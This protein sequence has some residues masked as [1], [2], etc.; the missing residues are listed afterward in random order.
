MSKLEE[1]SALLDGDLPEDRAAQLRQA[2]HDD[3]AIAAAWRDLQRVHAG[4]QQLEPPRV[5]PAL[6]DAVAP[7][8]QRAGWRRGAGLVAAAALA[9]LVGWQLARRAPTHVVVGPD[10]TTITG[11]ALV[12]LDTLQIEQ[13]G[14]ILIRWEEE[15]M[16]TKDTLLGAGAGAVATIAV[17]GGWATV[18]TPEG[19][20]HLEADTVWSPPQPEAHRPIPARPPLAIESGEPL[21]EQLAHLRRELE[22]LTTENELLT[23]Q[24]YQAAA[25][26][27]PWPEELH[28]FFRSNAIEQVLSEELPLQDGLSLRE[29]DCSE[30]PCLIALEY[31]PHLSQS[32]IEA[33]GLIQAFL[34]RA[35]EHDLALH[36][37]GHLSGGAQTYYVWT[38]LPSE[39]ADPALKQR[40]RQRSEDLVGNLE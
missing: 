7:R 26:D 36:T 16:P 28:P 38:L 11:R 29:L 6:L 1:L 37:A 14:T 31:A 23:Q 15:H 25:I 8:P 13:D 5:P 35:R 18:T 30:F 40:I 9:T 22:A 21:D 39:L 32:T 3:P 19:T 24:L 12:D 34:S 4:L 17:L 2:I 20:H 33:L 27:V 10:A